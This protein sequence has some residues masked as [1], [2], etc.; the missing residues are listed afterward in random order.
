LFPKTRSDGHLQERELAGISS[1]QIALNIAFSPQKMGAQ[2]M[3]A[4]VRP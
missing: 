4:V 3:V 1:C 2:M